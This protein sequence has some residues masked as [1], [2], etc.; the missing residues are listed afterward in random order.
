MRWNSSSWRRTSIICWNIALRDRSSALPFQPHLLRSTPMLSL[1]ERIEL[2]END[3]KQNPL[4]FIM[5]SDLPFAVFR[6]DPSLPDEGE[7]KM[8]RE[9]QN[10]AV[11]VENA[12]GRSVHILSLATLF[13]QS[14]EES[15]GL[16]ILV[17]FERERGFEAAQEQVSVYLSDRDWRP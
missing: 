3:L 11:R 7:W 8:R 17:E 14:I 16:D 1:K 6:Y 4:G 15:E 9:I 12:T 10:L 5:S 2:L 13:W